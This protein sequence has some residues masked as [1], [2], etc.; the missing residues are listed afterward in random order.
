MVSPQNGFTAT[1]LGKRGKFA[2]SMTNY[3]MNPLHSGP[4]AVGCVVD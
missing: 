3:G 1:A 4:G 2:I